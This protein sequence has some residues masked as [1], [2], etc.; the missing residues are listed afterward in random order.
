MGRNPLVMII[1]QDE[2][3][4]QEVQSMLTPARLA[5]VA[6]CG[7]GIEAATLAEETSPDLILVGVEE[8]TARAIHTIQTVQEILPNAPII[9]Y[10]SST[11]LAIVRPIM[12]SGVRDL[13]SRPLKAGELLAAIEAAMEGSESRT[14]D[15]P[16]IGANGVRASAGS[17]VTVFGAKGG[18]GKT[19]ITTNLAASIAKSTSAS[20]V[21]MDLDTRFGDVAI[22][23]D[24]EPRYTVAQ[25]ASSVSTLDRETFRSALVEH[26]SGAFVLPSPKHPND[27]QVVQADEI[28]E[29]IRFASR[30]FDYVLLDTPGTFN[31]IVAT[32]LEVSSEVLI[33]TSVDMASIKDTSFMLDLLESEAFPPERL[34]LTV[35]HANGANTIRGDDI[36]RVLGKPVFWEIPH[37]SEVVYAAQV[38]K[39][40]VLAK[41]RA[42]AAVSFAGLASRITGQPAPELRPKG[43]LRRLVP[44]LGRA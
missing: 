6:D 18:I 4:R 31:D 33:V 17:V 22:M 44:A 7:Y 35:N 23:L 8:P 13:L 39:P 36:G 3:Y 29:L 38:G 2:P 1:D 30:M 14:S 43:L 9:A 11:D 40:V 5:V 37:D 41:P 42:K 19:T 25:L 10:A 32:A 16:A 34:M 28:K 27:W 21:V 15:E 26:E 12:Q 20:V 24:V